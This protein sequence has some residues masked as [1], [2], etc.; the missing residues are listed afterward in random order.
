MYSS[1]IE[2]E[3]YAGKTL[4]LYHMT[5]S[6]AADLIISQQYMKPGTQGMFGPAIY[7]AETQDACMRKA[8]HK[9]VLLVATV[10]VGRSLICRKADY[11]L[12]DNKVSSHGCHSVKGVGCVSSVEYAI[13]RPSQIYNIKIVSTHP[14][15]AQV[16]LTHQ[17]LTQTMKTL[18]GGQISALV[19][20]TTMIGFVKEEEEYEEEVEEAE[21]NYS[22]TE[23]E[24]EYEYNDYL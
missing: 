3:G 13:Y 11:S 15:C 8:K 4:E 19:T 20:M 1:Y 23:E 18:F 6:D 10:A 5:S 12:D 22:I 14:L 7:F 17:V 24:F 21:Y 2:A 16:S 9:E